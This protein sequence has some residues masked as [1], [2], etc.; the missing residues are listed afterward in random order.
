MLLDWNLFL[1]YLNLFGIKDFI[2]GSRLIFLFG[3]LLFKR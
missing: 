3:S 2:V 1:I